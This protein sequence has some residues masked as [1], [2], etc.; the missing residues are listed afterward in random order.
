[1]FTPE[2]EAN[3]TMSTYQFSKGKLKSNY[4]K[5]AFYFKFCLRRSENIPISTCIWMDKVIY[6]QNIDI[7][8]HS[9]KL[10]LYMF[11]VTNLPTF[12]LRS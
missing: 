4:N 2:E 12:I 8:G 7:D 6:G 1:M 9:K 5:F 3:S 11:T 10:S